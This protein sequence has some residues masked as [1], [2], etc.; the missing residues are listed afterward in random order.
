MNDNNRR[1]FLARG[2]GAIT[3]A[4]AAATVGK[5]AM[6]ALPEPVLQTKP[7]TMPPLAPPGGRAYNPVVTVNGWTLPWRM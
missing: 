5:A 3:G 4:L 1:N 6:A 7:D 2:A